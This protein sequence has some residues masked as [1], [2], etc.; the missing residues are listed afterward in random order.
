VLTTPDELVSEGRL[1]G[2]VG[3]GSVPE[4]GQALWVHTVDGVTIVAVDIEVK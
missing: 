4:A 2:L 1:D 3:G